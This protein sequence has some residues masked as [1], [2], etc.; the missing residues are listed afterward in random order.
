[1]SGCQRRFSMDFKR[2]LTDKYENLTL[3]GKG[4]F[5]EV[6]LAIDKLN[7][8]KVAIKIIQKTNQINA[9]LLP[10]EREIDIL[11]KLN[12]INIP[13]IH[14]FIEKNTYYIL[15]MDYIE[16]DT[17]SKCIQESRPWTEERVIN[18]ATQLISVLQYIH[19]QGYIFCD[20]KP[21]NIMLQPNGRIMLIDFG[22]VQSASDLSHI[23]LGTR[24]FAAPEQYS[25]EF[26]TRVDIYAFGI[27]LFYMLTGM[28]PIEIDISSC[29]IRDINPTVSLAMADIIVKCTQNSPNKRYKTFDEIPLINNSVTFE[30]K[31]SLR[32]LFYIFRDF[33][34]KKIK[35]Y[36][37]RANKQKSLYAKRKLEMSFSSIPQIPYWDQ[38]VVLTNSEYNKYIS[39]SIL[40]RQQINIFLSYCH[41]DS[42]LADILC[43][44]LN[45][46]NFISISRYSNDVPYKGSFNEFMNTLGTHDKVIMIVS[47]MYLKSQACMYEVGQLINSPNFKNKI[48][49]IICSDED[50]KYYK[51]APEQS[52][53]AKIYDQHDRNQYILFWEDKCEILN[54]DLKK[55]KN[56]C[57]KIETLE[58]LRNINN[59]ISKDLG[60]FMKYLADANGISFT[61]L[62]EHDF[63]EFLNE[64]GIRESNF[65][66]D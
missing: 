54:D 20:L 8:T 17:I 53:S 47:D 50:K 3:I 34:S 5:S 30:E 25:Q 55:I 61:L 28:S 59:I 35:A 62:K 12:H 11:R 18:I 16:G 13:K 2:D 49:F 44:K 40:D 52:I 27:T 58:T 42:D 19:S 38:T 31:F 22:A 51:S 36:F 43:N 1:M 56:E 63:K 10:V 33:I 14:S 66:T 9:P 60:L 46:Y 29:N 21:S 6:Y 57:A 23:S 65:F 39:G 37:I 45:S 7:N 4:G 48:L 26:D 64:L 41:Q 24:G 32:H 15:V